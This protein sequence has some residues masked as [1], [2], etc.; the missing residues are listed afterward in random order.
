MKLRDYKKSY[1]GSENFT[2][3]FTA[4]MWKNSDS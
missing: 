1:E 4:F 2:G 3:S